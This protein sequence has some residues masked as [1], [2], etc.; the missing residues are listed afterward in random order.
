MKLYEALDID[1]DRD[2][3]L[4]FVG[5][6][7]KTTAMF[8]LARE[9]RAYGKRVLVTTTTAIFYPDKKDCD[10]VI[11]CGESNIRIPA[12]AKEGNIVVFGREISHE[13]KLSGID[14]TIIDKL[15]MGKT[16]DYILVEG[17]GSKRMPVKAPAAHEPVIPGNTTR[18]AGVIGLDALGKK[19][20]YHILCEFFQAAAFF[21]SGESLETQIHYWKI[22]LRK[23]GSKAI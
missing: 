1:I 11:A 23:S 19:Q 18:V 17:D 20:T 4:C 10:E 8:R 14:K 16:F 15:Y 6:G 21:G 3:L 2:E 9:L 12:R 7:G 13:N 5:A 22:A